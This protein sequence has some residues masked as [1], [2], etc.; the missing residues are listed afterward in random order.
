MTMDWH[1]LWFE[2]KDQEADPQT[3]I[4]VMQNIDPL[5]QRFGAVPMAPVPV[6][7]PDGT[8][9]VRLSVLAPIYI[10]L[11]EKV[12]ADNGFELVR[13]ESHIGE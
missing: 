5:L 7:L 4:L 12:A 9:E 3:A 10:S 1:K 11:I 8:F 13:Q 6:Q 2:F